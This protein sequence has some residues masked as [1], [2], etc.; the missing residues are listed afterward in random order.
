MRKHIFTAALWLISAFLTWV[1][2][3]AGW[4]KFSDSSG[5]AR[6]FAHWGF[7]VWFRILVGLVEVLGGVLLLLPQTAVYAAASLAAVMLGA[8]GTHVAD[9]DPV[10]VYHEALPLALLGVVIY[11]RWRE[12]RA[13]RPPGGEKL[14]EAAA[15]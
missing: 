9:G 13:A 15:K 8:M 3:N 6:A 10:A 11:L 7:P 1:F 14:H 5:W 4:P 2:V 12:R